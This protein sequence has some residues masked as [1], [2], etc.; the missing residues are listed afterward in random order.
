MQE[1]LVFID[2]QCEQI[3]IERQIG[4]RN[5]ICSRSLI[6]HSWCSVHA[7]T[8]PYFLASTDPGQIGVYSPFEKKSGTF[9]ASDSDIIGQT[10]DKTPCMHERIRK[11]ASDLPDLP[12]CL[13]AR[14]EGDMRARAYHASR[15][16]I[17]DV[18]AHE[19]ALP[20]LPFN[21]DLPILPV[22][23][24]PCL[25]HLFIQFCRT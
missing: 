24:G 11:L 19:I 22:Q 5:F 4:H 12:G 6:A 2:L 3:I 14:E 7:R 17:E 1:V 16:C 13:F 18:Q 21:D 10:G 25:V 15:L 20:T 8:P 23:E 9:R